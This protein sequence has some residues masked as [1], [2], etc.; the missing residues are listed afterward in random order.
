GPL[1]CACFGVSAGAISAA[2][3]AGDGDAAAIGARLKAGTNCGSCLPEIA[4]ILA[5][6]IPVPA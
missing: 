6:A 2:I 5:R 3:A 1:V 4:Q